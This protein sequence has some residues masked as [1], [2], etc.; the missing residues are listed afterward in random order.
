MQGLCGLLKLK[1]LGIKTISVH[2]SQFDN[3]SKTVSNYSFFNFPD[4]SKRIGMEGEGQELFVVI[5]ASGFGEYLFRFFVFYSFIQIIDLNSMDNFINNKAIKDCFVQIFGNKA[6]IYCYLHHKFY[7][8]RT[9]LVF[10]SF[11]IFDCF[12][13]LPLAYH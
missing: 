6:F 2:T 5:S 1:M 11:T 4:S 13:I 7:G 3:Q 8:N 10:S 12:I 9:I